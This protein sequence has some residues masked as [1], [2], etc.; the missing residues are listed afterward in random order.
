[1]AKTC[2]IN[3]EIKRARTVKKYAAKRAEL[4]AIIGNP[5]SSDEQ[6]AHAMAKLQALPRDASPMPSAQPMPPDWS[7]AWRLPQVRSWQEQAARSHHAW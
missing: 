7:F 3:R 6:R 2:M 5:K 4:K 1:M